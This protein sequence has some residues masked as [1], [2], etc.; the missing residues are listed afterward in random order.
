MKM[1]IIAGVIALGLAVVLMWR[2]PQLT[3]SYYRL[4]CLLGFLG[5]VAWAFHGQSE[6]FIL[7][8]SLRSV[9]VF[10]PVILM[11]LTLSY[12]S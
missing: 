5:L 12:Y 3:P 8:N 9:L 10:I 1:D 6:T 4:A 11:L 2:N 7:L